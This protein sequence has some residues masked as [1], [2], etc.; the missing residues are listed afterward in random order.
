MD[1][2]IVVWMA[3]VLQRLWKTILDVEDDDLSM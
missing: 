3:D 2:Y 1:V